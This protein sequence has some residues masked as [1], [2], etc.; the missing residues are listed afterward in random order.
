MPWINYCNWQR[1][2]DQTKSKP[3]GIF[4]AFS[5]LEWRRLKSFP[6]CLKMPCCEIK[7]VHYKV[8][9][10]FREIVLS[11]LCPTS[12]DVSW[13]W[14]LLLVLVLVKV[15]QFCVCKWLICGFKKHSNSGFCFFN[16]KGKYTYTE[17]LSNHLECAF[18]FVTIYNYCLY[19]P[20]NYI[21]LPTIEK[22]PFSTHLVNCIWFN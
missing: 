4:M 8:S 7:T 5:T 14:L 12:D 11:S 20:Y 21:S 16:L 22:R 1:I 18:S 10:A 2:S 15:L 9:I 19:Y 17:L 6:A 3:S 13:W